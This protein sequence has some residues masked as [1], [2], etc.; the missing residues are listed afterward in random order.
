MASLVRPNVLILYTDQ[1]CA[2]TLSCYGQEALST[3][4][5]DL[6]ARAGVRFTHYFVQNPV[7]AP[8]RASFLTG[9]YCSALRIGSNGISFPKEAFPLPKLLKPYGYETAQIG[10]LHFDPHARRDHRNP[11][12]TYGFDTARH[13]KDYKPDTAQKNRTDSGETADPHG[14][15][16]H[17]PLCVAAHRM[18][19]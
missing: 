6:L 18:G 16:V 2:D 12:D 8:S 3:P 14:K 7:G 4:N 19:G 9:R 17:Q 11:T 13:F 5:I 15:Y 1:Q 10:K